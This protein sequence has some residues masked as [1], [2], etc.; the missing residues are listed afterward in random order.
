[1]IMLTKVVNNNKPKQRTKSM[2][3]FIFYLF[4]VVCSFSTHIY[5]YKFKV[6]D[7][8][9]FQ[10]VSR[11]KLCHSALFILTFSTNSHHRLDISIG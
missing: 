9:E 1:M 4:K 6:K 3:I 2:H 11:G 10:G 7:F 5:I 8:Q